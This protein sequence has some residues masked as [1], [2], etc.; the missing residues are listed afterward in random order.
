[1]AMSQTVR[2]TSTQIR[3]APVRWLACV[4][5]DKV[6]VRLVLMLVPMGCAGGW[7]IGSMGKGRD[8]DL[9]LQFD[10][11]GATARGGR[12]SGGTTYIYQRRRVPRHARLQEQKSTTGHPTAGSRYADSIL[13]SHASN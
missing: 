6:P 10:E 5:M 8:G 4:G 11:S 13:D 3:Y 2:R 7:A 9:V 1:M 12:V